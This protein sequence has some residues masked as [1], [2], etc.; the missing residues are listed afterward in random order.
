[1]IHTERLRPAIVQSIAK[2]L[3][4]TGDPAQDEVPPEFIARIQ[5]FNAFQ[6]LDAYLNALGIF[7]KTGDLI[8]AVDELRSA[9]YPEVTP[10]A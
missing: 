10:P 9:E 6:A 8:E 3:G 2:N 4:W 7:N 5:A 1:M